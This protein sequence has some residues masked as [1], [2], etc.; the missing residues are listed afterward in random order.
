MNFGGMSVV[1]VGCGVGT[2]E[3]GVLCGSCAAALPPCSGLVPEHVSAG[4][5]TDRAGWLIDS[6][7]RA[8]PLP[9][10]ASVGRRTDA[11]IVLVA[12]S[13]SRDHAELT[14]ANDE[15][16]VRDLGS[17][18]GTHIDG[19]RVRGRATVRDGAYLRF[20]QVPV[21]FRGGD[22]RMP[23][24]AVPPLETAQA[25]GTSHRYAIRGTA[26]ELVLLGGGAT[27]I[28]Q[29]AGGAGALLFRATDAAVWSEATLPALE[30]ALLEQLCAAA[31]AEAESVTATRG[32]LA[33]EHLARALPFQTR[34]ANEENVQQ[35]VRRVRTSLAKLGAQDLLASIPG[36]GYYLAWPVASA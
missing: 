7:G 2:L 13:V 25:S 36:R 4:P 8:H 6:W 33:T 11:D 26:V 17:R 34:Y 1:C 24:V 29:T 30:F 35:V 10:H 27:A 15:W 20:G 18:N 14:W 12:A 3:V 32:I 23:R 9:A 19:I 21:L 22:V 16:Q 5:V 28:E 31:V